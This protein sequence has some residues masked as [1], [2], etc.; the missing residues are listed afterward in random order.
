[1]IPIT[2]N[3]PPTNEP[4]S[5]P[6]DGQLFG[7]GDVGHVCAVAQEEVTTSTQVFEEEHHPQ[8]RFLLQF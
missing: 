2:K 8:P 6:H 4:P 5:N 3:I 7:A 1:M